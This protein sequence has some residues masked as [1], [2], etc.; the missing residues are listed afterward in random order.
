M[1][2]STQGDV[3]MLG[4]KFHAV[5]QYTFQYGDLD[6][7]M[8]DLVGFYNHDNDDSPANYNVLTRAI[9]LDFSELTEEQQAEVE[10][11]IEF[12]P[13]HKIEEH[14]RVLDAEQIYDERF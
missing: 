2:Y 10:G 14:R 12:S 11:V 6:I 1:T 4:R 7:G 3:L 9:A 5:V 13:A 8:V